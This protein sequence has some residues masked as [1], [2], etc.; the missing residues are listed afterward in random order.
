MREFSRAL[1]GMHVIVTSGPTREPLDPVRYITNHS[2]GKQGHAIAAAF[3][4]AGARV[5]L[6]SGP[7][8]IPDPEGVTTIHVNTAAQ[9]LEATLAALPA[10]VA[11]CAAAVA[12][13]TPQTVADHKMKKRADEDTLTVT[14]VKTADILKTVGHH[15]A[16]PSVVVGFAAE[17]NDVLAYGR[18]KLDS[19]NADMICANDVSGGAVFGADAT[20]LYAITR[21]GHDDWGVCDKATAAQKIVS[22]VSNLLKHRYA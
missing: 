9:M 1:A 21:N 10:D 5:T 22:A 18:K 12:D 6:I 4:N 17:T 7:V 19:K 2:S 8:E 3:A 20:H 14:F 11:V 13:W 15:A 16:R